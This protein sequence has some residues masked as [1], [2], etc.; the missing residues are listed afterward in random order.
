VGTE[1]VISLSLGMNA[2]SKSVIV[3]YILCQPLQ[4]Q[5]EDNL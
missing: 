3:I 1:S 2:N 5:R 4:L